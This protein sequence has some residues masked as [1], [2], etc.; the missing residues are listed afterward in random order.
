MKIVALAVFLAMVAGCAS[1]TRLTTGKRF[2]PI[3]A[4][5]VAVYQK[6]PATFEVVGAVSAMSDGRD[7]TDM[8]SAIKGLKEEASKIGANGVIIRG[9]SADSTTESLAVPN[10]AS[11]YLCAIGQPIQLYGQA[12]F[13]P[14]K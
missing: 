5:Q 6:P 4:E 8:E 14:Q 9:T 13:V 11:A 3:K 10:L 12:I 7:R 1:G 2:P